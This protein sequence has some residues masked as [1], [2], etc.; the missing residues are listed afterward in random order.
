MA[1]ATKAVK[2][3]AV[4]RFT[5]MTRLGSSAVLDGSHLSIDVADII[6]QNQASKTTGITTV[7]QDTLKLGTF[8]VSIRITDSST[9]FPDADEKKELARK[10]RTDAQFQPLLEAYLKGLNKGQAGK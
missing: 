6:K 7:F 3:E 9:E 2:A 8:A 1:K 4:K 10:A 5:D